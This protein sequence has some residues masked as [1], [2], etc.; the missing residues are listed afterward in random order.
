MRRITAGC[1]LSVVLLFA[2]RAG[3]TLASPPPPVGSPHYAL[4]SLSGPAAPGTSPGKSSNGKPQSPARP[5]LIVPRVTTPTAPT[6]HPTVAGAVASTPPTVITSAP[7]T[8]A[9]VI[10][11]PAGYRSSPV[12]K[13]AAGASRHI[14]HPVVEPVLV[15]PLPP[16]NPGIGSQG[17]RVESWPPASGFAFPSTW[18]YVG[19]GAVPGRSAGLRLSIPAITAPLALPPIT[20]AVSVP[21]ALSGGAPAP[22]SHSPNA[23]LIAVVV[24]PVSAAPVQAA[25]QR[26]TL[27]AI[28]A[29]R[30]IT[31]TLPPR[32]ATPQAYRASAPSSPRS[33]AASTITP[34]PQ[35]HATMAS[36]RTR[37]MGK[38]PLAQHASLPLGGFTPRAVLDAGRRTSLLTVGFAV[39]IPSGAGKLARQVFAR[40]LELAGRGLRQVAAP[41]IAP[42]PMSADLPPVEGVESAPVLPLPAPSSSASAGAGGHSGTSLGAYLCAAL[43]LYSFFLVAKRQAS[44]LQR[45]PS[46]TYLPLVPPG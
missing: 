10:A 41:A 27:A 13:P 6:A 9:R 7:L 2:A 42:A 26:V 20:V 21:A 46:L 32:N 5:A 15:S 4:G 44:H 36:A 8:P 31:V 30:S 34:A 40:P 17:G 38:A 28:P 33:G 12:E 45:L 16:A 14:A 22:S 29:F 24:H 43:M 35:A 37:A 23:S 1:L 18:P 19:Q 25:P 39:R 3:I 11:G